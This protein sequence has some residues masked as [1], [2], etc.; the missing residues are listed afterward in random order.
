MQCFYISLLEA[1]EV[2]VSKSWINWTRSTQTLWFTI[3][4]C[5]VRLKYVRSFLTG[6]DCSRL[7]WLDAWE[8]GVSKKPHQSKL[9]CMVYCTK[10]LSLVRLKYVI[11]FL[12]GSK[13]FWFLIFN[14]KCNEY[15]KAFHGVRT[16]S[17]VV[18]SFAFNHCAMWH[19]VK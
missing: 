17:L 16:L 2:R 15:R 11:S 18:R 7:F 4:N 3:P 8:L 1:W 10:R 9:D 13:L 5:P 19:L 14:E 12:T 6:S